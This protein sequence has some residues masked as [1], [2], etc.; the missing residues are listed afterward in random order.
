[1]I[2]TRLIFNDFTGI[3]ALAV[4]LLFIGNAYGCNSTELDGIKAAQAARDA[5]LKRLSASETAAG[6]A[7]D[8][9]LHDQ[10]VAFRKQ[11]V[12]QCILNEPTAQ[13]LSL[14]KG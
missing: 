13:A 2:W 6:V 12:G 10:L 5:E 4:A 8:A 9:R 3:A 1:M 11:K 7:Q 14:I